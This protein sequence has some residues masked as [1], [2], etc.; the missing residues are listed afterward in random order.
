LEAAR[1]GRERRRR[2]ARMATGAE[3]RR[4]GV[5]GR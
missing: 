1:A 3:G 2:K 4:F 5:Q